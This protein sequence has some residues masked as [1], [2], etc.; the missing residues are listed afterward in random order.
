MRVYT[1]KRTNAQGRLFFVT[2]Y[3]TPLREGKK[4]GA[5]IYCRRHPETKIQVKWFNVILFFFF[6]NAC[7][8]FG[9]FVCDKIWVHLCALLLSFFLVLFFIIYFYFKNSC[10]C[11]SYTSFFTFFTSQFFDGWKRDDS[12][13]MYIFFS[14]CMFFHFYYYIFTVFVVIHPSTHKYIRI[15][16]KRRKKEN[17]R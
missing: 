4:E 12:L 2:A 10:Q 7:L 3:I 17:L 14:M 8:L 6:S 11:S 13:L 5:N 1:Y 15:R 16:Y 9:F